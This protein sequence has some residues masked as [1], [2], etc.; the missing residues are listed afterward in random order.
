MVLGALGNRLVGRMQQMKWSRFFKVSVST[1]ML[2]GLLTTVSGVVATEASASGSPITLA[3]VTS[4]TGPGASQDAGSQS[5]FLARIALQNSMGGVNGHKLVGLVIDDQTNPSAI[6]TALQDALAKGAFGIVSQSPLL[7]LAD[8]VPNTQGVPV[9]GSYDDGPEW[10]KQPF[11]NM[12]ASDHGSV[13]PTYPVNTQIGAFLKQHGGT[14]IGTYGYGISPLSAASARGN[15][16]SFKDAG[17]K[18]GVVDTSIPFGGT[19]FTST[20]LVAKQDG[21]NTIVPSMDNNSNFALATSLKQAGVKLKAALYATGYE[22]GVIN[23]PVWPTLRGSYFLSAFRPFS[24]PNSGTQQMAAALKKYSGFTKSQFPTF[25][26]VE[27]WLGAD[28]MIQ[29]LKLAGSNPT[30]ATVIKD[31]RGIKAYTGN[32][33]LPITINYSTIFG[34]DPMN[35]AW[36]MQA[37]KTGFVPVSS[38]PFCGHDVAGTTTLSG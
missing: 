28:L 32:G 23:S 2:V 6:S 7:F 37:T 12:F 15:A 26:Q 33:L 4:L 13:D 21:V 36:V 11:T 9:T 3:Y 16:Q 5:G 18:I 30:R 19:N 1:A 25:G 8:K 24:L 35:C 29:G 22:P 31:L 34:H 20:A 17:G 10:G 38:K 14:V 27:S